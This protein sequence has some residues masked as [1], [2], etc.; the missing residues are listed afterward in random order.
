MD[1]FDLRKYLGS[2]SLLNEN[3]PGYDTRKTGEALPT[4]ES[5]KAAY[6]AKKDKEEEPRDGVKSAAAKLGM[7]PSHVKEG[8][9][10]VL[11]DRIPEFIQKIQDIKDEYHAVVG[12]DSVYDGLDMAITAAEELLNMK[13]KEE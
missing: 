2:K 9:W 3:A 8:V 1:N 6:E 13:L 11:P 10:S 12:S 5:V 7:K 4:L